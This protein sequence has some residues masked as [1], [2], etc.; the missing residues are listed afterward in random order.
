[1]AAPTRDPRYRPEL[2]ERAVKLYEAGQSIRQIAGEMRLSATRVHTIL[3]DAGVEFRPAGR[4][5]K[6]ASSDGS[7]TL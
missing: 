2:R 5:R 4:P 7:E 1:M 3:K 6:S